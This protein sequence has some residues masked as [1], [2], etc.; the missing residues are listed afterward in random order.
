MSK[1]DNLQRKPKR[2]RKLRFGQI[3]VRDSMHLEIPSFPNPQRGEQL[4]ARDMQAFRNGL[5]EQVLALLD[6]L[7]V[8]DLLEQHA[9]AAQRWMVGRFTRV[10][11]LLRCVDNYPHSRVS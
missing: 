11:D 8:P 2:Q 3:F 1:P 7:R 9:P 10:L 4:T 5:I 6:E